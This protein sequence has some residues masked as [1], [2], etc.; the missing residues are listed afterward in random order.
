MKDISVFFGKGYLYGILGPNGS[1]KTTL[2]KILN[3][4]L[5]SKIGKVKVADLDIKS[6]KPRELAKLVAFVDQSTTLGFNYTV[7]EII[8][9]G[10]FSHIGRFSCETPEDK[11]IVDNVIEKLNLTPLKDRGFN[12]ISGGEQQKVIIAKALAQKSKILLLDEPTNHLDINYQIELMT[13]LKEYIDNGLIVVIVLHDINLACQF[14]DKI[15]LLNDG[16]IKALGS[17]EQ[18]ITRENIKEIYNID[19]IVSKNKYT[20]SVF[21]TPFKSK[22]SIDHLFEENLEQIKVHVIVGGGSAVDLLPKLKKY[23]VSIG[24][25]NVID[26]DYDLASELNYTIV[27]EAPFS[28]IS[29][30]SSK[31]LKNLLKYVDIVILAN[32]SFG[33][34]NLKN[35]EILYRCNKKIIIYEKTPIEERDFTGG[36]AAKL[37]NGIKNL[38]NT[39]VVYNIE[40]ILNSINKFDQ[41]R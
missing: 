5:R 8:K 10:R 33:K 26:D 18:T 20:G 24:V 34:A 27:A 40:N 15:V 7:R 9:M 38:E 21:I 29:H 30:Q 23:D 36:N 11:K 41:E 28:K 31:K 22:F 3:G 1:G 13:M 12:E 37:Y 6:L 2:L 35:L 19:V 17:I 14:C 39:I 16:E 25:V 32:I 4:L